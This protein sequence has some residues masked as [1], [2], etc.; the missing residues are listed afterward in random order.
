MEEKSLLKPAYKKKP[1][2]KMNERVVS[3]EGYYNVGK[4][5]KIV[6]VLDYDTSYGYRIQ[7]ADGRI[8]RKMETWLKK[9][10]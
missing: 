2:F 3:L 9:V 4:A 1:R 10:N 5:G 6:A 7:Y 8:Y